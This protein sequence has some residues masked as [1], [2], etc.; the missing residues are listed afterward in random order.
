MSTRKAE[1][2]KPQ[3]KKQQQRQK[4]D[5]EQVKSEK[6]VQQKPKISF[7]AQ[8]F[9]HVS[10]TKKWSSRELLEAIQGEAVNIHPSLLEYALGTAQDI[11]VNEDEKC[12][13]FLRMILDQI[14]D[15]P[16]DERKSFKQLI[17]NIINRTLNFIKPIRPNTLAVGNCIRI[18]KKLISDMEPAE[19][20]TQRS[21]MINTIVRFIDER[22]TS[23][24]SYIIRAISEKIFNGDV[25][26]TYGY[27][28]MIA[29]ALCNAYNRGVTFKVIVI[30]SGPN[31]DSKSMLDLLPAI[32]VR[33]LYLSGLS[34]VMPEVTKVII[35][36][37]GI[38]SNNA[39]VTKAGSA[40]VS[41]VA[42]DFGIPVLFACPAYRF[43]SE[44]RVDALTK[45]EILTGDFMKEAPSGEYLSFMYDVTPGT[46]V[47]VVVSELGNIPVNSVS[48]NIKFLQDSYTLCTKP[49]IQ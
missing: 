12:E 13:I 18:L 22:I 39:A 34:Y 23:P 5:V 2:P 33:Y 35:E 3:P 28:T 11:K 6:P 14:R 45:N 37:Y 10:S 21:I 1:I 30:D 7:T 31:Y 48:T 41:M 40:I 29:E 36:P 49:T 19:S 8:H 26:L 42:D 43:V 20:E 9:S 16:A 32:D 47:D 4:K 46:F 27:S 15:E 44:V 38:L 24:H 25:V 17:S